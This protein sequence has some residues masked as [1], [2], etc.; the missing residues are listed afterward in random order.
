MRKTVLTVV[1][2]VIVVVSSGAVFLWTGVYHIAAAEPHATL[3]RWLLTTLR[4]PSIAARAPSLDVPVLSDPQRIEAGC[5]PIT[6]WAD[7]S[8]GPRAPSGSMSR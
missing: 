5:A 8:F 1:I 2:A 6:R 3:V 7:M 4:D